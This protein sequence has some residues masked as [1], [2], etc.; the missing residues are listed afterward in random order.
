MHPYFIERLSL[1]GISLPS[2][3]L[4]FYQIENQTEIPGVNLVEAAHENAHKD[5]NF[6]VTV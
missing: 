1:V 3:G 2:F 4:F 5:T 6:L